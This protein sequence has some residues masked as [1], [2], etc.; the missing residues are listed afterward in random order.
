MD[1][2]KYRLLKRKWTLWF[3]VI[4]IHG[5]ANAQVTSV[6]SILSEGIWPAD[7]MSDVKNPEKFMPLAQKFA[8]AVQ[9]N[10]E[11]YLDYVKMHQHTK[12]LPYHPN[13]GVTQQEYEEFRKLTKEMELVSSAR[14]QLQIITDGNLIRFKTTDTS[15]ITPI[16]NRTVIDLEKNAVLI[17]SIRLTYEKE[18]RVTDSTNAMKSKWSGHKWSFQDPEDLD[19]ENISSDGFN[20]AAFNFTVGK[21]ESSGNTLLHYKIVIIKDGKRTAQLDIPLYVYINKK[22]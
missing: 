14:I 10:R 18:V 1:S 20:A 17:D 12:P 19:I 9:K 11:W 22:P 15:G 6:P 21:L 2:S 16:L 4:F 7:I 3:L 13:L 8:E 5:I